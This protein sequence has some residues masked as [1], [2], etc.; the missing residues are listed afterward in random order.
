M[1]TS[2]LGVCTI[3]LVRFRKQGL[4]ERRRGVYGYLCAESMKQGEGGSYEVEERQVELT[5]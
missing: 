1:L 5:R 4:F 3:V 2:V